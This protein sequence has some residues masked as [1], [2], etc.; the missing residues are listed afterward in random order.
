MYRAWDHGRG[1]GSAAHTAAAKAAISA[2][3]RRRETAAVPARLSPREL[4]EQ[5]GGGTDAYDQQRY[6]GLLREHGH[7]LR[8]GDDGY[9]QRDRNLSCGWP[10]RPETTEEGT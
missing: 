6:L 3:E 4:W 8:P 1:R 10:G 5:A 7:L 9:E 2:A